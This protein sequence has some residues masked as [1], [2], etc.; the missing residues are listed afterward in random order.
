MRETDR[1]TKGKKCVKYSGGKSEKKKKKL[2]W[3]FQRFL[4]VPEKYL[5]LEG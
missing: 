3:S 5:F 1:E 2:I 4:K